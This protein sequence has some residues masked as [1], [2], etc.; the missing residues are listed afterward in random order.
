VSPARPT[1]HLEG[2]PKVPAV[3]KSQTGREN[4]LSQHP[5]RSRAGPTHAALD[6]I[7]RA[8]MIKR[9]DVARQDSP[10]GGVYVASVTV[11]AAIAERG[12]QR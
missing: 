8:G 6:R 2:N 9:V 10:A 5:C 4:T 12:S 1:D 3:T 7:R 11:L